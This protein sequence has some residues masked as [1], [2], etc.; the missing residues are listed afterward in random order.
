[1]LILTLGAVSIAFEKA[2]NES[3][4]PLGKRS[5]QRLEVGRMIEKHPCAFRFRVSWRNDV[6]LDRSRLPY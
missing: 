2:D 5:V 1:M 3:M 6:M 4:M